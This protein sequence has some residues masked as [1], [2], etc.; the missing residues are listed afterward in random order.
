MKTVTLSGTLKFDLDDFTMVYLIQEDG[1][2]LDLVKRFAEAISNYGSGG[3]QVSYWLSDK[4]CTKN[5]MVEG[6][7]RKFYGEVEAE[8]QS[9]DY[10]YSIWTHGTDYNTILKVGGHDLYRELLDEEDKFLIL[11]MNFKPHSEPNDK[12]SVASKA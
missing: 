8:Y 11:E 10:C 2:K 3:V 1:Y 4:P 5:E 6:W 7:L 9:E 12:P